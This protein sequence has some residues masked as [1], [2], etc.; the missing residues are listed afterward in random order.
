MPS[1]IDLA[2]SLGAQRPTKFPTGTK[3]PAAK[4]EL[5]RR[6]E[7]LE[8]ERIREEHRQLKADFLRRQA[9][10]ASDGER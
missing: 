1:R 7:A 5:V 4:R 3:V 6:A 9:E 2:L 10:R 8:A